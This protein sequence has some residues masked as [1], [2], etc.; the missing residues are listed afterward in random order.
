VGD[1]D[2][3]PGAI[4]VEEVK[5][6]NWLSY[7]GPTSDVREVLKNSLVCVLPSYREGRPRTVMEAMAM[8]RACVVTDVPGCRECIQAGVTGQLVPPRD[9][10]ALS[11]AILLYLNDP[12]L[13]V[14]HGQE[15]RKVAEKLYPEAIVNRSVLDALNLSGN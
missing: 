7:T 11:A 12:S 3:A 2:N 14:K 15:A 1:I 10:D 5:S 4:S 13:A 9:A 6:W 8:R